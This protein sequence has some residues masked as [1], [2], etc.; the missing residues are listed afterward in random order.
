ME[1]I[2]IELFNL[3][4]LATIL[5][6]PFFKIKGRGIISLIAISSQV[7]LASIVAFS[8]FLNGPI[9]FSY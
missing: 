4:T 7:V 1:K 8:V 9:N 5:S 6:F 3:L 2:L